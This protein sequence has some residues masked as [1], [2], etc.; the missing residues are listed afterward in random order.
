M[1]VSVSVQNPLQPIFFYRFLY[2][3]G[4]WQCGKISILCENLRTLICQ[5]R[6]RENFI[7]IFKEM[8]LKKNI[9]I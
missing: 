3:F 9:Y 7:V 6:R 2:R 5:D 8:Q 4:V 1:L